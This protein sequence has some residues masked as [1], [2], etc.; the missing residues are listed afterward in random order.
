MPSGYF[1][2][3][4]RLFFPNICPVCGERISDQ[5]ALLCTQCMWEIPMTNYW[6]EVDNP[7]AQK[8]WGHIP[9]VNACSFMTYS[10]SSRFN[11]LIHDFKYRGSWKSARR[12][13]VWYGSY[14]KESGLYA[15]IDVVV[16]VPL[17]FRKK[18]KRGY[19]QSQYIAEGIAESL[20]CAVD[21]HSV[22]RRVHN[23]SQTTKNSV[24]RWDNVHGIFELRALDRLKGKHILLVDD[25]LTTGATLISC[26]EAILEKLPDCRLSIAVI[27]G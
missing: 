3:I 14:L 12:L 8:F 24:E 6:N 25:V 19:N 4:F 5:G 15:D 2:D 9:I 11:K 27:A 20:G 13:G 17:H 16:A 21:C 26:A 18:L 22:S 1:K 7:V 23:Q 10:K